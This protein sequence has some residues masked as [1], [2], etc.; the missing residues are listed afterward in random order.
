MKDINK[1]VA[2]PRKLAL[3]MRMN[4]HAWY[5]VWEVQ[6]TDRD[7]HY[8]KLP[9]GE[10]REQPMEG[11]VR[12]TEPMTVNFT[13]IGSE[14]I[15]QRAVE[16]LNAE[17][18]AAIEDLNKKIASIRDRKNQLLALTHQTAECE[19]EWEYTDADP[20]VGIVTSGKTCAKCGTTAEDDR[21]GDDDYM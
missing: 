9:E 6:Y 3:Y 13:A 5:T 4:E 7:E 21:G 12:I 18:R 14:E 11:Y 1:E 15:V 10:W 20:S 8:T 16:S 17:E 19:H 2:R